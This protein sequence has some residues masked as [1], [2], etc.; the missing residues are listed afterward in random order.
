[1][2]P[3]NTLVIF[4]GKEVYKYETAHLGECVRLTCRCRTISWWS[5]PCSQWM[6]EGIPWNW[7][8]PWISMWDS[9]YFWIT[10]WPKRLFMS[11]VHLWV[12]VVYFHVKMQKVLIF[13]PSTEVLT[14]FRSSDET[15]ICSQNVLF[16]PISFSSKCTL[17]IYGS[18]MHEGWVQVAS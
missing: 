7:V 10:P 9:K 12:Y 17:A 8:S 18:T 11:H 1:M 14:T 5:N 3:C 2:P 6:N 15:P 13:S 4:H 16:L